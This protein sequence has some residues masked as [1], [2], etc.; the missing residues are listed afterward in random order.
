LTIVPSGTGTQRGGTIRGRG[1][2]RSFTGDRQ[3]VHSGKPR[4]ARAGKGI[5]SG[6]KTAAAGTRIGV[7]AL[8]AKDVS[9]TSIGTP[10]GPESLTTSICR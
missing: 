8:V 9:T 10:W 2:G 7:W 4:V 3:T 1:V 6:T 5:L